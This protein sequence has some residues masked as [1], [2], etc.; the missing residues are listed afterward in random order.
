MQGWNK[1]LEK[2]MQF[3]IIKLLIRK[4]DYNMSNRE[5]II[6]FLDVVL[7]YKIGCVLAYV[8]GVAA[9]EEADGIKFRKKRKEGNEEK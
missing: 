9:G 7:D 4:R 2:A 1:L 6:E 3:D 5:R 8:Q